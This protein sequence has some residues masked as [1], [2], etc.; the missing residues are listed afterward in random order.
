LKAV[1]RFFPLWASVALAAWLACSALAA[2]PPPGAPD[3]LIL[4]VSEG[5]SKDRISFTYRGPVSAEQAKRDLAALAREFGQPVPKAKVTTEAITRDGSSRMTSVE[6]EF[7]GLVDRKNGRLFLEPHARAFR[8]LSRMRVT[9]FVFGPFRPGAPMATAPSDGLQLSVHA[10]P[11]VFTFDLWRS[12]GAVAA[13]QKRRPPLELLAVPI[14]AAVAAGV[15]AYFAVRA[16][17]GGRS[18]GGRG[19]ARRTER[20][21][22][23][24]PR[25]PG[26]L[27]A[28]AAS[29][30]VRPRPPAA[31]AGDEN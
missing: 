24:E 16:W 19:V 17:G 7:S 23:A 2:T 6:T 13:T 11:P 26:Q 9:Y 27:L 12:G 14:L 18:A 30:P 5:G 25:D 8:R 21:Q 1:R 29:E 3:V 15:G 31:S 28:T 10:Q 20:S 4:I 22:P